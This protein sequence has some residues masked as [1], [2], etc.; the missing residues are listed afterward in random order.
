MEPVVWLVNVGVKPVYEYNGDVYR[1]IPRETISVQ[2]L[3]TVNASSI[4]FCTSC[5]DSGYVH[6]CLIKNIYLYNVGTN[7]LRLLP[8]V[9][10]VCSYYPHKS[11]VLWDLIR[12]RGI[13][14]DTDVQTRRKLFRPV[15]SEGFHTHL[16]NLCPLSVEELFERVASKNG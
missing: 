14:N 1:D 15:V 8:V 6:V 5:S 10:H 2:N 12:I 4:S 11:P 9:W 7:V 3:S 13:S 16:R